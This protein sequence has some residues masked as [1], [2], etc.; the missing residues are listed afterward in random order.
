[1]TKSVKKN[2]RSESKKRGQ[3]AKFHR[4]IGLNTPFKY[5]TEAT[6]G[7]KKST[8]IKHHVKANRQIYNEAVSSK[9][10]TEEKTVKLKVKTFH[11]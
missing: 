9:Q 5:R 11:D 4:R 8:R 2:T 10:G 7:A 6:S 1:M 3:S